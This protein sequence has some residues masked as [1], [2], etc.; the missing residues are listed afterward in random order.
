MKKLSIIIPVYNNELNIR[1]LYKKLS[2]EVLSKNNFEY[3][4]I[5]VD[6]GSEDN[7]YNELLKLREKNKNIKIIKFTRNF[8]AY[9]AVFAGLKYANG[10]CMLIIPADLQ[11]PP[12]LILEMYS[13]WEKDYKIVLAVRDDREEGKIQSFFSNTYWKLAKKYALKNTPEKGYDSF[14]IDRKI[15]DSISNANEK[16]SPLSA[17][18]LW[19]GYKVKKIYYERKKRELGK[20]QWTLSKKIKLFIDT[21]IAFSYTPIRIISGLGIIISLAAFI[22]AMIILFNKFY[23]NIPIQG[24]ASL[25]IV[26]LSLSGIQLMTL[27]IIGEYLWRNFDESRKR[28]IYVIE[29]KIGIDDKK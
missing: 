22:F 10:N 23:N 14:L 20:S 29:K 4:I 15:A 17:Q 3:E 8:G 13:W 24:W 28:P 26:L 11:T 12:K 7:S 6:D 19:Y 27:A 16:N 1:T 2:K 21:F 25:M 5:F 9:T 18:I